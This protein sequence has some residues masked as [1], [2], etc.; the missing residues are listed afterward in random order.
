VAVSGVTE[1][2]TDALPEQPAASEP[3]TIY[4]VVALGFAVTDAPV[5][6]DKPAEGLQAYV[7]APAAFKTTLAPGQI[8]AVVGETVTLRFDPTVTVTKVD[9]VQ[10]LVLVTV[11]EYVV[12]AD[13]LAVTVAPDIEESPVAGDH[14]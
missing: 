14:V 2:V 11:T 10:P 13:G 12:V 1:I 9:P 6:P 5:V 8:V 7:V 4:V 3:L